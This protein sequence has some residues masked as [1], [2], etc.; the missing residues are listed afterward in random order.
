MG[1]VIPVGFLGYMEEGVM[2]LTNNGDMAR[3][4][5]HTAKDINS[6]YKCHVSGAMPSEMPYIL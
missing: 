2:L 4:I 5:E 3:T 6:V 1:R